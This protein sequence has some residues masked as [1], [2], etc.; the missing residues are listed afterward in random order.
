[1]DGGVPDPAA[2]QGR[3]LYLVEALTDDL[4]VTNIGGRTIV[5]VVKRAIVANRL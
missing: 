2:E 1:M 4:I 3:G 5:R